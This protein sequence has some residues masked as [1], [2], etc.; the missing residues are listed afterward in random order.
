ML[1]LKVLVFTSIVVLK[2][3]K[4]AQWAQKD[5]FTE[6]TLKNQDKAPF[7]SIQY[8]GIIL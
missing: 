5:Y 8:Y 3:R 1:K 7:Y 2:E 6:L 4:Y